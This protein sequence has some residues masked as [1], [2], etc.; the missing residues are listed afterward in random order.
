LKSVTM[1]RSR[2]DMY[3]ICAKEEKEEGGREESG[4]YG[5]KGRGKLEK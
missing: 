3:F 4:G 2:I 5:R 1:C